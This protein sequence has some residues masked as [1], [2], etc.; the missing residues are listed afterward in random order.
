MANLKH[1]CVCHSR[2]EE[3]V[4]QREPPAASEQVQRGLNATAGME[5]V[6]DVTMNVMER[7][8][9]SYDISMKRQEIEA[10]KQM[11]ELKVLQEAQKF[12]GSTNDSQKEE[13]QGRVSSEAAH[14]TTI[15]D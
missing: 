10:Q 4:R 12:E 3:K 1:R 5:A 6:A 15:I 14:S 8:R 7:A 11:A 2:I 13:E 9:Y